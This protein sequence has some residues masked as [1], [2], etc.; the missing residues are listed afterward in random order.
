MKT[1][2]LP[3]RHL[4]SISS[5]ALSSARGARLKCLDSSCETSR[6][7]ESEAGRPSLEANDDSV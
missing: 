3:V 5:R 4:A 1:L 2:W 7:G 6:D